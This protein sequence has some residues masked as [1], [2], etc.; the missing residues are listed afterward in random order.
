MHR[1]IRIRQQISIAFYHVE[2]S[3]SSGNETSLADWVSTT[4]K[5]SLYVSNYF[6]TKYLI[7]SVAYYTTWLMLI[8]QSHRQMF[9]IA[10]TVRVIR[11]AYKRH[12]HEPSKA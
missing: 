6:L 11:T 9:Q 8:K 1:P 2:S 4:Y 7:H 12:T 3:I 5:Y 10:Y